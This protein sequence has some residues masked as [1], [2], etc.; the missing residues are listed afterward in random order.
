MSIR[1]VLLALSAPAIGTVGQLLLKY[2]MK[3]VGPLGLTQ[4][5][6]P[7]RII[8][9]LLTNPLF[10]LAA[11]LYALGF[12]IWLI[13]LSKMD[14][15]LAYPILA[16][17]YFLVPL[18]SWLLFGEQISVLRWFGIAIICLGVVVVGVSK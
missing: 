16:L 7:A 17:S 2:V 13:V 12:V 3:G 8:V 9:A 4:L 5:G 18:L 11:A 10:L 6:S 14:L 1:T 15:S